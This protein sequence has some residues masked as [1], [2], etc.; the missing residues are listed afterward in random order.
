VR[1][2]GISNDLQAL[3]TAACWVEV[4]AGASAREINRK[5]QGWAPRAADNPVAEAARR[6]ISNDL[7]RR[8]AFVV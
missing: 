7:Q 4:A 1:I 3:T 8:A 6:R 2:R 5:I